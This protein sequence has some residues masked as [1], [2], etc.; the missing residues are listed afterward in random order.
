MNTFT[1]AKPHESKSAISRTTLDRDWPGDWR[2]ME[3]GFRRHS[4]SSVRADWQRSS[5]DHT[6]SWIVCGDHKDPMGEVRVFGIQAGIL[7]IVSPTSS[8]LSAHVRSQQDHL[9]RWLYFLK[10]KYGLSDVQSGLET[11][12]SKTY[13][14]TAGSINKLAVVSARA[15]VECAA[16]A[17]KN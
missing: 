16:M 5:L 14:V 10:E 8:Q 11:V 7:L 3:D 6:E 4:Q 12:D 17:F 2:L 13:A 15:C 1:T 9:D